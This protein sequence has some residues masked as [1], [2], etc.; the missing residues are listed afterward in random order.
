L[1][2][3]LQSE[4]GDLA[5]V[6]SHCQE[7][8]PSGDP[9]RISNPPPPPPVRRW[10]T[11][12]V[13]FGVSVAV[14]LAPLLGSQTVPLFSPL[15]DLIPDIFRK[16]LIPVTS[17][18]MGLVAILVQ[19]FS[20]EDLDRFARRRALKWCVLVALAGVLT[21]Y[22]LSIFVVK[23]VEYGTGDERATKT[24][25]IGF[26]RPYRDPCTAKVSDA[27]CIQFQ[28]LDEDAVTAFWG[29]TNVNLANLALSLTYLTFMLGF[30]SAV[31]IVMYRKGGVNAQGIDKSATPSSDS[32]GELLLP[33]EEDDRDRSGDERTNAGGA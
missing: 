31:G 21:F 17:A 26:V 3:P 19:W 1:D 2:N 32:R 5:G 28:S 29:D 15:L 6:T 14:G 7:R 12:M 33:E 30:A 11:Y 4:R 10:V 13:A 8:D 9:S 18:L 25:L 24:F 20:E 16:S 27:Q 23:N 22:V